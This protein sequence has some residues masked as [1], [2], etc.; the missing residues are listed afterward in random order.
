MYVLHV[1]LSVA[2]IAIAVSLIFIVAVQQSKNEGFG[3]SIGSRPMT[4]FKGKAGFEERL[5]QITKVL[6][7]CFFVASILVAVTHGR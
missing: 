5:T 4:S 1:L 7:V 3:G 6:G 2:Q